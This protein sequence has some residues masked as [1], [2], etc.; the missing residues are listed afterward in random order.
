MGGGGNFLA[1]GCCMNDSGTTSQRHRG[2]F[3][4][5]ESAGSGSHPG[6]SH[7]GSFLAVLEKEI[8]S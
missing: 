2:F 5:G 6:N 8:L 1:L 7:S 3:L 4:F